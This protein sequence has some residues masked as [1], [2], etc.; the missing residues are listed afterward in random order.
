MTENAWEN[1]LINPRSKEGQP[2]FER[3]EYVR[4]LFKYI[5]DKDSRVRAVTLVGSTMKG[6]SEDTPDTSEDDISSDIDLAFHG[7]EIPDTVGSERLYSTIMELISKFNEEKKI[8]HGK[9]FPVHIASFSDWSDFEDVSNDEE[10]LIAAGVSCV[11]PSIGD[12]EELR[13]KV[14]EKILTMDKEHQQRILKGIIN[15][16]Y[17]LNSSTLKKIERGV[18]NENDQEKYKA[19]IM[20]HIE[21]RV[22]RIFDPEYSQKV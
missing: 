19:K 14:R 6:Y 17:L 13:G 22:R 12:I 7:E 9:T 16:Q 15:F 1:K 2:N 21:K 18:L 4:E 8:K 10:S 3:L 20:E 5:R 11:F